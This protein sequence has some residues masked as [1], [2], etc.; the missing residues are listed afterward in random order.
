MQTCYAD[1]AT[2]SDPVFNDLNAEQVR[3]MWAMLLKSGKDLQIEF[4]NLKNTE[5][6]ATANWNAYY[7]FS[8]TGKK[9]VNKITASFVIEEGKIVKH[10]DN[11]NFHNWSKQALGFAGLLLGWTSFLKSKIR[12]KA[13][14][15]LEA[16]M[17]QREN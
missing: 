15:N 3:A 1:D 11:F 8:A 4:D 5:D 14:K 7:T 16:Y 17:T 2:F 10:Q 6:G 13:M 9:V 12:K